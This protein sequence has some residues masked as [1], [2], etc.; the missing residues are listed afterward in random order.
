MLERVAGE[1]V[2]KAVANWLKALPF[3]LFLVFV[4]APSDMPGLFGT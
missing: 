1:A 2:D 4:S 3:W